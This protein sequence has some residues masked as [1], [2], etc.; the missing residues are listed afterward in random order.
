MVGRGWIRLRRS[1]GAMTNPWPFPCMTEQVF[2]HLYI[3][4]VQVQVGPTDLV[5]YTYVHSG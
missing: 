1:Q 4:L 5:L 2:V 3:L